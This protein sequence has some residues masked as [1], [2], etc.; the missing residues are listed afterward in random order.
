M[1]PPIP[2][3]YSSPSAPSFKCFK[4]PLKPSFFWV[5][6]SSIIFTMSSGSCVSLPA[7]AKMAWMMLLSRLPNTFQQTCQTTDAFGVGFLALAQACIEIACLKFYGNSDH[8][9]SLL[10]HACA[11]RRRNLRILFGYVQSTYMRTI[12]EVCFWFRIPCSCYGL[13]THIMYGM[14]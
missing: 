4:I 5:I 1:Y 14:L 8:I 7:L 3:I 11:D 12:N 10:T 13:R 2:P 6:I 9:Q